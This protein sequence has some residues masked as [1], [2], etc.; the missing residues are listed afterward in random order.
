M[1]LQCRR[2]PQL[3]QLS[4]VRVWRR[5][6]RLW[7]SPRRATSSLERPAQ[8]SRAEFV[9]PFGASSRT[10]G[11]NTPKVLRVRLVQQRPHHGHPH[12][13]TPTRA[14]RETNRSTPKSEFWSPQV[15]GGGPALYRTGDRVLR[16]RRRPDRRYPSWP[17]ASAASV[18]PRRRHL[19]R[20]HG[21]G[22]SEMTNRT[23][24]RPPLCFTRQVPDLSVSCSSR[25]S[26]TLGDVLAS[27]PGSAA[28]LTARAL[29]GPCRV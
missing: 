26:S 13:P 4:G 10:P 19:R 3:S 27:E 23:S 25:P 28:S 9:R 8:R 12:C 29:T 1:T 11:S 15:P 20:P 17:S 18:P 22:A 14:C 21:H 24:A 16:G 7:S 2:G 6:V 5:L